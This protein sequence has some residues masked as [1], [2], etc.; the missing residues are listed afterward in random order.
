MNKEHTVPV[1]K[2]KNVL[3]T[4]TAYDYLINELGLKPSF[5][6]SKMPKDED[7]IKSPK[8]NK[9]IHIGTG[10]YMKLLTEYTEEE[11]LL[12]RDGFIHSP[13]STN[14]IRVFGKTFN[15][16]LLKASEDPKYSLENLLK[17][18]RV[19]RGNDMTGVKYNDMNKVN[20]KVEH[21]KRQHEKIYVDKTFKNINY[22]KLFSKKNIDQLIQSGEPIIIYTSAIYKQFDEER[23]RHCDGFYYAAGCF[24][25]K[26]VSFYE[27]KELRIGSDELEYHF[28]KRVAGETTTIDQYERFLFEY[29]DE[30]LHECKIESIDLLSLSR[31]LNDKAALID[32]LNKQYIEKNSYFDI[33]S[34]HLWFFTNAKIMKII[35]EDKK[36]S[37]TQRLVKGLNDSEDEE[38]NDQYENF[39]EIINSKKQLRKEIEVFYEQILN[40]IHLSL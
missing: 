20:E 3:I 7:R 36:V 11:L 21:L 28:Q 5:L 31:L 29:N 4:L 23:D 9:F 34:Q 15:A 16:L 35:K 17:N 27:A 2:A 12:R 19:Q 30:S 10:T 38:Y 22:K 32:M 18:P 25:D 33:V 37:I 24:N 6:L 39:E 13:D 26:L 40:Y 1:K 8:S 14:L